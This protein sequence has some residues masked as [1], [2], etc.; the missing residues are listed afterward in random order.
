MTLSNYISICDAFVLLMDPL[1]EIAIHDV[2]K[3]KIV[4]I[5][6]KLS[7]RNVN[8]ESLIHKKELD[9][10]HQIIYPKINFDGRLIKSVS[11]LLEKKWL[12]CIN[13]DISVFNQMHELSKIFIQNSGDTQP[14]SLFINDWQ[15]KLHVSIHTYLG[16][17]NLSFHTLT[18]S[19]KK[20]LTKYLYEI[21][22]F[23]EKNA[24][25]YI[26]K[27]LHLGRATI[28]NYLK[29]WKKSI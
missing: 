9:E 26:A 25:D 11:V 12:L 21:G 23:H 15:E 4:Y 24:A 3:N 10:L 1:I 28:F 29:E 13:C 2:E 16:Q 6:G 17:N 22:A 18:Q 5:N 7:G 8:E 27:V 14:K 20:S 19:D